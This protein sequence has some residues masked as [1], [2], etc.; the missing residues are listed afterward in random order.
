M[1]QSSL[2]FCGLVP[3]ACQNDQFRLN[4]EYSPE[5]TNPQGN[6][7]IV[8]L[9][10]VELNILANYWRY[11]GNS[12]S[13]WRI[14]KCL[15]NCRIVLL[16]VLRSRIHENLT[17]YEKSQNL[18]KSWILTKY[19]KCPISVVITPGGCQILEILMALQAIN[20]W[21]LHLIIAISRARTHS[22]PQMNRNCHLVFRT[23]WQFLVTGRLL[24][25]S[26]V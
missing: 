19:D 11:L 22:L 3:T 26:Q 21:P 13:S 16:A 20:S 12:W 5:M 14:S 25:R 7:G 15:A 10:V 18:A 6:S 17:K 1:G 23:K 4:P 8:L 9:A 24:R 2:D